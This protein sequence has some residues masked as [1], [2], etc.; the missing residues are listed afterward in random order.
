MLNPWGDLIA[1]AR[2]WCLVEPGGY[3]LVGV[4]T[5]PGDYNKE[6]IIDEAKQENITEATP[7]CDHLTQKT[8][9]AN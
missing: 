5:G 4:P 8:V 9:T 6:N 7:L 1:M 3:G 2:S